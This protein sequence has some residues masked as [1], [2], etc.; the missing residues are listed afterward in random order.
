MQGRSF[1]WDTLCDAHDWLVDAFAALDAVLAV[2]GDP[3]NL[4]VAWSE[5]LESLQARVEQ[6]RQ[7]PRRFIKR[8]LT[9]RSEARE[10]AVR[11]AKALQEFESA[12][13]F[14]F[15][16]P[17]L[18]AGGRFECSECPMS[19]KTAAAKAAHEANKHGRQALCTQLAFGSR[20]EVCSKEFW[21]TRRL[22]RHL[23]CVAAC[24]DTY[25]GSDVKAD[26]VHGRDEAAWRPPVTCYGPRPFWATFAPLRSHLE[27]DTVAIAGGPSHEVVAQKL[28]AIVDECH[29]GV[30]LE[31]W[32]R[33]ILQWMASFRDDFEGV[34]V[35]P[36]LVQ[37]L[38]SL[39]VTAALLRR[40]RIP[41]FLRETACKYPGIKSKVTPIIQKWHKI[42]VEEAV[43][44]SRKGTPATSQPRPGLPLEPQPSEPTGPVHRL[45]A[46]PQK[47]PMRQRRITFFM[48]S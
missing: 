34:E 44:R 18:S 40:T 46:R 1:L 48:H 30:S 5:K 16:V 17:V 2:V 24:R 19:F 39:P 36:Q 31:R 45:P 15:H 43:K 12:G 7:L 14:V 37:Q 3:W 29:S 26:E 25:E 27:N 13:G 32:F 21:S 33:G 28:L 22:R 42:Y 4:G 47:A 23:T 10:H 8:I 38:E 6:M 9:G 41:K 11:K 35:L 20:C